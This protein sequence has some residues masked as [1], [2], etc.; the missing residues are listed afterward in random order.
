MISWTTKTLFGRLFP[1]PSYKALQAIKNHEDLYCFYE[2]KQ[3]IIKEMDIEQSKVKESILYDD[4]SNINGGKQYTLWYFVWR[5]KTKDQLT[6]EMFG[7]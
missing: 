4:I 3:M 5:P 7:Y 1:C 2:G 6:R